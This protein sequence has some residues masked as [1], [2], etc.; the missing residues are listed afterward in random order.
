MDGH[1]C[2][3]CSKTFTR[4]S[5]LKRHEE[6][7]HYE[8]R[9]HV[10]GICQ[11][12]FA[13]KQHKEWHLRTCSLNIQGGGIKR[14]DYTPTQELKFSPKLHS[15]AFGGMFADWAIKLPHDYDM[16]DPVFLLQEAVKS[17]KDIIVKHLNDHTKM[18]KF[19]MSVHTIFHHGCDPEVKSNPPVVL[20]TD[21]VSV[22]LGTDL[23]EC[24]QEAARK[25]MEL[26][27]NY[28]GV[29]SGWILDN[30][31]RLDVN[32]TSFRSLSS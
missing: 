15:S 9:Q 1:N 17:M 6:H 28:E 19:T 20:T 23:D 26:V 32:L 29:G 7:V 31:I 22:Y 2:E 25:L 27:E 4:K 24:L 8:K 30:I 12:R 11:K 5:S 13:R 3:S 21:P 18:L 16:I 10:C 14:K